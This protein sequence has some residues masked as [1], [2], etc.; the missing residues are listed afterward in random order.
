MTLYIGSLGYAVVDR[1]QNKHLI[2]RCIILKRA[3]KY[4]RQ[5][6]IYVVSLGEYA[7]LRVIFMLFDIWKK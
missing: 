4:N 1:L 5:G 2:K 6:S 7:D 3:W